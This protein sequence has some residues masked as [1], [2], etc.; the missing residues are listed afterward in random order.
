MKKS[1]ILYAS[2]LAILLVGCR[3]NAPVAQQSG[4]EDIDKTYR[5]NILDRILHRHYILHK[6]YGVP[7]RN[8]IVLGTELVDQVRETVS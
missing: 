2:L 6:L 8:K 5:N 7:H 3:A 1:T 4:K